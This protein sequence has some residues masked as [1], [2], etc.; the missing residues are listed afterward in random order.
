MSTFQVNVRRI[1][2]IEPHT[3]ADTLEFA[4]IDDFRSI[5]RKGV[6]KVGDLAVYIPEAAVLPEG[7]LKRLGLWDGERNKGKCAGE[8]GNRVKALML[9]GKLSQ[10]VVYPLVFVPLWPAGTPKH[11]ATHGNWQLETPDG[12]FFRVEEGTAVEDVLGIT[13]FKPVIPAELLGQ[14][15][16]GG[17][18][19]LPNFDIENI[20]AYP[21]GDGG[22]FYEGEEVSFHEKLHGTF[23]GF[24]LLPEDRAIPGHGRILVFSKGTAAD[25]MAFKLLPEA[26]ANVYVK[27]FHRFGIEAKL[28]QL[29]SML[30]FCERARN[31]PVFILGEILGS[32]SRQDLKYGTPMDF[33]VFDLGFGGR[34]DRV[35]LNDLEVDEYLTAMGMQ[36]VPLI[37]RGPFSKELLAEH[38][39]GKETYSGKQLHIREGVVVR[40]YQERRND[41]I[42]RVILK[43]VSPQYLVRSGEATEY[44]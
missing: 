42:G 43:S 28:M 41:A 7:V 21:E 20:K 26:E 38:S 18:E 31:Q 40:P 16:D 9:R 34:S 12:K 25:A 5:V 14:C 24:M 4:V 44:Q 10:G 13:K 22:G 1:R 35:H 3:N 19:N 11:V 27:A 39:Q 17:I 6:H 30:V 29:A 23:T 37:Y 15:I 36:R 8:L 32:A 33:R 2:A